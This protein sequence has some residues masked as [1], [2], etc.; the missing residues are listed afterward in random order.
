[1]HRF[2]HTMILRNS[3]NAALQ[4]ANV[5]NDG[6]SQQMRK[7]FRESAKNWLSN[8]GDAYDVGNMNEEGWCVAITNFKAEL[9]NYFANCLRGGQ[10]NIGVIQ[11][12]I[13]LY[14][15]YRWLLGDPQKRPFFAV[16]DRG[17]MDVA[18]VENPPNWTELNDMEEYLL[19]VRRIDQ[20]AVGAE[21]PDGATWEAENWNN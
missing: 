5:Y 12:M 15:K 13:S 20:F 9:E 18:G 2:I 19:V 8:F 10:I 17:I 3:V 4:R 1:M 21:Y 11:K 6:F 14:L 7:N 16:I